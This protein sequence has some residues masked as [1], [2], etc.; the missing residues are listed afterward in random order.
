MQQSQQREG[1]RPIWAMFAKDIPTALFTLLLVQCRRWKLNCLP[2]KSSIFWTHGSL[3]TQKWTLMDFV[4]LR[5]NQHAIAMSTFNCLSSLNSPR[6]DCSKEILWLSNGPSIH[7]LQ[8]IYGQTHSK[9]V[10]YHPKY[11]MHLH[12]HKKTIKN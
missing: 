6:Q 9:F 1:Q 4:H 2:S 3:I 12:K 7:D 8:T 11:E 5:Q 10:I